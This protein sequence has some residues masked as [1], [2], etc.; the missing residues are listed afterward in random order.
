[1][2]HLQAAKKINVITKFEFVNLGLMLLLL[3]LALQTSPENNS[4]VLSLLI[5]HIGF[6]LL[7]QP[8]LNGSETVHLKTLLPITIFNTALYLTL[9]DWF[10]ALWIILLTGLTSGSA[11]VKGMQRS[12]YALATVILFLQLSL[13][14]TPRLFH[15][16]VLDYELEN[17]IFYSIFFSCCV[18]IFW[19]SKKNRAVKI[20]YM[21]SV[22]ISFGL[23]SFYITSILISFTSNINYLESLLMTA[24]SIGLFFIL[25]SIIWLPRH[26]IAGI[27]QIWE[28]HIL[29]I[30]NPFESWVKQTALLGQNKKIT[31]D[32]FLRNSIKQLLTLSWVSGI[33]WSDKEHNAFYGE[34]S[35]HQTIFEDN[36]VNM[37]LHSH[38]PMGSALKI[39]AQLLMHLMSYFYTSKLREITLKNQTHLKAVY[40]TGSKLTHDIKNILQA[41]QTLTEV[42]QTSDDSNDSQQ[43]IKKQL[44]LLTQRLQN[45]LDKLQTKTDTGRSFKVMSIW[46]TELQSRY[47]GRD[48]VFKGDTSETISIDTDVFD[49]V[50]ENLLENARSKRRSNPQTE[51]ISSISIDKNN[52]PTIQVFDNGDPVPSSK[53]DNLFKQILSS[54]DGYGIGLYQSA[55]LASRN[56]YKLELINNENGN[57]CFKISAQNDSPK[58]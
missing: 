19:P 8:S 16:D 26:G 53:L 4:L 56:G 37:T 10:I 25:L 54:K 23:F 55:Q 42:V 47:H 43:L 18:I 58:T 12:L 29:N 22:L 14:L 20:D 7:W 49:T 9:G 50:M 21:H 34:I 57:V 1:M 17:I 13:T 2:D 24:L 11:L 41:L 6:F 51:I 33:Q 3:H 48:I 44:P 38:I 36:G 32:L 28:Q 15:F 40:E 27:G 30:G 46:W 52:F 5:A 31:P 45:T 35:H 39:H